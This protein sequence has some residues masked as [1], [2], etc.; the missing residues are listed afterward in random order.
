[1]KVKRTS[2]RS[3]KSQTD[4]LV[5]P[6]I[7]SLVAADEKTAT[8][9]A[10]FGEFLISC[11]RA[12]KLVGL[13]PVFSDEFNIF[14]WEICNCIKSFPNVTIANISGKLHGD[15]KAVRTAII[16][17]S[18]EGFIHL[19]LDTSDAAKTVQTCALTEQGFSKINEVSKALFDLSHDFDPDEKF[20]SSYF[21]VIRANDKIR[22]FVLK[23]P[24]KSA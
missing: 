22:R 8:K 3:K 24:P 18:N 16:R 7:D 5:A 23:T 12:T 20:A 1:M 15:R 9:T 2:T 10:S 6:L 21:R 4:T 19:S 14:D 11:M 17:L 13:L